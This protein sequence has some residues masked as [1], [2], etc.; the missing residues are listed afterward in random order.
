MMNKIHFFN[1]HSRISLLLPIGFE[2]QLEDEEK[3]TVIYADDLDDDDEPGARILAKL[4]VIKEQQQDAHRLLSQQR[5]SMPGYTLVSREELLHHGDV[6]IL[7]QL[8]IEKD[9]EKQVEI[10]YFILRQNLLFSITCIGPAVRSD[11]YL[12]L[13][14]E[15]VLS[16]RLILVT[17]EHPVV[18]SP[19]AGFLD[20]GRLMLSAFVP[21]GWSAN[22]DDEGFLRFFGPPMPEY[23]DSR[24]TLSI[25]D[26]VPEVHTGD[27]FNQLV[28]GRIRQL[29]QTNGYQFLDDQKLELCDMMPARLLRYNW[30]TENGSTSYIYQ[31]LIKSGYQQYHLINATTPEPM[32]RQHAPVFDKII[33][34]LRFLG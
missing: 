19:H 4:T 28:E 27:W 22:E 12:P 15:A 30:Q 2:E 23:N 10:E 24:P 26:V 7:Q 34:G 14:R 18:F 29:Q 11:E 13:F 5:A 6:A 3:L 31:V 1:W 16:S 20:H 9:A 21:E 17:E 25:T 8:S 32:S 33:D